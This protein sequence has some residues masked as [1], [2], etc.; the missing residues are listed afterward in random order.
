MS[1]FDFDESRVLRVLEAN[2]AKMTLKRAF[3][4]A[5]ILVQ[6]HG[7]RVC[8]VESAAFERGRDYTNQR[9]ADSYDKGYEDGQRHV[10]MRTQHNLNVSHVDMVVAATLYAERT[11]D[12]ENLERRIQCIKHLRDRFGALGIREGKTIVDA[13][14]GNGSGIIL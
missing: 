2:G 1:L 3:E 5:R 14:S 13:C 7:E 11:F 8:E 4:T 6:L 12:R 10:Q 9:V